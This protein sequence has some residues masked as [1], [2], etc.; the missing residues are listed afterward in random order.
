MGFGFIGGVEVHREVKQTARRYWS[1][2]MKSAFEGASKDAVAYE[3]DRGIVVI[4]YDPEFGYRL[5]IQQEEMPGELEVL[6]QEVGHAEA[7]VGIL[8]G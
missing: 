8:L 6:A 5:F 4:S 3:S 2:G 7:L 1:K